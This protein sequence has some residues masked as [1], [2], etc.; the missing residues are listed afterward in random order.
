[1]K[2]VVAG[3][4]SRRAEADVGARARL[5]RAFEG[6]GSF[7]VFE[8]GPLTVAWTTQGDERA[9]GSDDWLCVLDGTIYNLPAVL[10]EAGLAGGDVPGAGPSAEAMLA[11]AYSRR[12]EAMLAR[13]RGDFALLCWNRRTHEGILVRDQLGCGSVAWSET[14]GGLVFA[15]EVSHLLALLPRTP[16]PDHA[17][18]AHWLAR[19]GQPGGRTLY[20]GVFRLRPSH[21]LALGPAPAT[22]RRYWSPR[23]ERPLRASRE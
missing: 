22:P 16:G 12:G 4:L 5:E 7:R 23:Y 14:S 21:L 6:L 3:V 8:D 17:A 13:L 11:V 1:M 18:V 19:S 9:V 10:G 15:S 20:D 2:R